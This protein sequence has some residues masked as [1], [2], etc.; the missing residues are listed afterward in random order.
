MLLILFEV[1]ECS[2]GGVDALDERVTYYMH[3]LYPV[4]TTSGLSLPNK[5]CGCCKTHLG[6]HNPLTGC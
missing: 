4:I 2:T 3:S 5:T 6:S 1:V